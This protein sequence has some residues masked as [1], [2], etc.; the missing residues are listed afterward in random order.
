MLPSAHFFSTMILYLV[1]E[2]FFPLPPNSLLIMLILGIGIDGDI[3]IKEA[4]RKLPTHSIFLL[5]IAFP[6][7]LFGKWYFFITF[8]TISLHLLLDS[9]DWEFYPLYP[10]SKKTIGLSILQKNSNIEP[11]EN[12]ILDFIKKYI[13]NRKILLLEIILAITTILSWTLINIKI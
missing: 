8:A 3:L 2:N 5:L 4:H 13:S 9:L 6:V 1:M 7:L 12:T 11:E 10:F